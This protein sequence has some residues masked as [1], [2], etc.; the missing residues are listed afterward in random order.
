MAPKP[1]VDRRLI[2]GL[3]LIGS[4]ALGKEFHRF[5]KDDVYFIQHCQYS[6]FATPSPY[7]FAD[8]V[9]EATADLSSG[10]QDIRDGV[11]AEAAAEAR[12]KKEKEDLAAK[13]EVFVPRCLALTPTALFITDTSAS[14]YRAIKYEAVS[15]LVYEVSLKKK[16]FGSEKRLSVCFKADKEPD[17]YAYLDAEAAKDLVQIVAKIMA[18][19]RGPATGGGPFVLREVPQSQQ[20]TDFVSTDVPRSFLS[21]QQILKLNTN[22]QDINDHISGVTQEVTALRT[23]LET[24]R[25]EAESTRAALKMM[26]GATT[27]D[28]TALRR[29]RQELHEAHVALQRS[30]A[31]A[32]VDVQTLQQDLARA[33]E[34]LNEDKSN[35]DRLVQESVSV[36]DNA[37]LKEQA[38]MTVLRQKAQKREADK[39]AEQLNAASSILKA[40]P[41]AYVGHPAFGAKAQALEARITESLEKWSREMETANKLEKFI[42]NMAAEVDRVDEQLDV[43]HQRKM[44]LIA[45]IERRLGIEEK[46]KKEEA[47]AAKKAKAA[48][49]AAAKGAGGGLDDDLDLDG[50]DGGA[51]NDSFFSEDGDAGAAAASAKA[52]TSGGASAGAPTP[53]AE[54]AV[55]GGANRGVSVIVN[56][57]TDLDDDL[58]GGGG[59]GSPPS[60]GAKDEVDLDD[61]I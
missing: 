41:A 31:A 13:L 49:E 48:A 2:E 9:T 30:A 7:S 60:T 18:A 3:D 38:N 32:A 46:K 40:R 5:A 19:R 53:S 47:A 24:L 20:I 16:L 14:L 28:L 57:P 34:Q 43:Q 35:Y 58:L 12:Q 33:H 55:G 8:A 51:A 23:E 29:R 36:A 21:A 42:G 37:A 54:V 4:D 15:E 52:T 10:L 11:S 59:G 22:R 25:P 61:D 26:E 27:D 56:A 39:L 44:D 1:T 45:E 50:G 17:C 6:D